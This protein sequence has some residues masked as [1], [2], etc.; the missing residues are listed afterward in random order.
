MKRYF[1]YNSLTKKLTELPA[2]P[3]YSDEYYTDCLVYS[4][5]KK[6]EQLAV[7]NNQIVELPD[8]EQYLATKEEIVNA[9]LSTVA[10]SDIDLQT[11]LRAVLNGIISNL[12][13]ES[14]SENQIDLNLSSVDTWLAPFQISVP[15]I[16][17]KIEALRAENTSE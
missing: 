9:I 17:T 14:N 7:E 13:I 11:S 5:T 1:I 12:S 10:S 4:G 16:K 6:L 8:P 15:D 2:S 3:H